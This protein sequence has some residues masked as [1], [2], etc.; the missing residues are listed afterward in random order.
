LPELAETLFPPIS[1]P[2]SRTSAFGASDIT[3]S[4]LKVNATAFKGVR[5]EQ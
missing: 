2:R 4:V 3:V 5:V 1:R